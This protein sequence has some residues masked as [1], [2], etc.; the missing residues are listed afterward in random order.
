MTTE[1]NVTA[2][3]HPRDLVSLLI[4]TRDPWHES[5]GTQA[6]PNEETVLDATPLAPKAAEDSG[7]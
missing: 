5:A 3:D 7:T 2:N 4:D 6:D 1:T